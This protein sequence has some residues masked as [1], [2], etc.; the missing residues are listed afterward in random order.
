MQNVGGEIP[1]G[2]RGAP[3]GG[4]VGRRAAPSASWTARVGMRRL[5]TAAAAVVISAV[6]TLVALDAPPRDDVWA[7][8][9]PPS[10][11]W[12]L[13]P[14]E[15][16][17][18]SRLLKLHGGAPL[19]ARAG[20]GARLF[21]MSRAADV[22]VSDDH[23]ATWRLVEA[24]D[25]S[26]DARRF[27]DR[28][29]PPFLLAFSDAATG[30]V[31]F[32][33]S[34][35]RATSLLTEDGG[36]TW[37]LLGDN[38]IDFD[39]V[40]FGADGAGMGRSGAELVC[41]R[42][43]GRSWTRWNAGWQ[44]RRARRPSFKDQAKSVPNAAARPPASFKTLQVVGDGVG[45]WCVVVR[46]DGAVEADVARGAGFEYVRTESHPLGVVVR[47]V[48]R[49]GTL[50][51]S[52]PSG[53]SAGRTGAPELSAL[54]DVVRP[55]RRADGPPGRGPIVRGAGPASESAL[56][57]DDVGVVW[58]RST[59]GAW[60]SAGAAPLAEIVAAAD[61]GF[62][63]ATL[64]G[65]LARSTDGGAT[66]QAR[67]ARSRASRDAADLDGAFAALWD[68]DADTGRFTLRPLDGASV[69]AASF[70]GAPRKAPPPWLYVALAAAV[71]ALATQ[72]RRGGD[73]RGDARRRVGVSDHGSTD[74]PLE[75]GDFDA[76]GLGEL[77]TKL[78]DFIRNRATKGPLSIAIEG[79][80][81]SGKS[82][83][84]NLLR[85]ELESKLCPVVWFNAWHHR[86][87]SNLLRALYAHVRKAAFIPAWDLRDFR[88]PKFRL[89]LLAARFGRRLR[90]SPAGTLAVIALFAASIT[91]I[92][93]RGIPE[94][95]AALGLGAT[96]PESPWWD[97]L[98]ALVPLGLAFFSGAVPTVRGLQTFGL[99]PAELFKKL[100][101]DAGAPADAEFRV[102]FAAEFRDVLGRLG[103]DQKLVVFIDDLDRCE[104]PEAAA[105][106]ETVNYLMTAGPCVVVAGFDPDYVQAC[107]R[108]AYR[109]VATELH[110]RSGG[111]A[112]DADLATERFA[113][114]F[115]EKL[116]NLSEPVPTPD[117]LQAGAILAGAAPRAATLAPAVRRG[118]GATARVLKAAT[119]A[120][121][122]VVA[123]AIGLQAT[124]AYLDADR[125]AARKREIAERAST[126]PR[127]ATPAFSPEP[128]ASGPASDRRAAAPSAAPASA[129]AAPSPTPGRA[130]TPGPVRPA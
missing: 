104:P 21:A 15:T 45:T 48:R 29:G 76:V 95:L 16:D 26:N 34:D 120:L 58:T 115:L 91:L 28:Y 119:A 101:R 84:M 42:D 3:V 112:A 5:A 31:S 32:R 78:G 116:V 118:G 13:Q 54:H 126:A 81:G 17:A 113:R 63:A 117:A 108:I 67:T 102:A 125:E 35:G 2:P 96:S 75:P 71:G 41:T 19:L 20:D 23:G 70:D 38:G 7:A 18:P 98:A 87:E 37:R 111:A 121:A 88:G 52:T 51:T 59:A 110:R 99:H 123:L 114:N 61:G 8:A 90:E 79:K 80:W 12:W 127:P 36:R 4:D 122:T 30:V 66:W 22:A 47:A 53:G 77:A 86:S 62:V 129:D 74:R 92:A 82:S 89:G 27:L 68:V 69:R 10:L 93:A 49:D 55:G 6:A 128:E 65:G 109:N 46:V 64:C 33:D 25:P 43:G 11:A 100:R 106:L 107:V 56:V 72:F 9:S 83:L 39:E 130:S 105:M 103:K 60:R 50:A 94:T 57:V 44:E 40:A 124:L 1:G 97:R 85:A 73:A 14:L 24:K